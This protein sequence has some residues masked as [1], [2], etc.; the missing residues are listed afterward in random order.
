MPIVMYQ[1]DFIINTPDNEYIYTYMCVSVMYNILTHS[2]TI[3]S[4]RANINTY[5][6]TGV[7]VKN[8]PV[9]PSNLYS[10]AD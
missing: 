9:N 4:G 10:I 7:K 6:D 3:D 2:E 1:N 8:R 5:K